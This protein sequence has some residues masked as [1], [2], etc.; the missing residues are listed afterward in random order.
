M[1][2]SL[3]WFNVFILSYCEK[4]DDKEQD[5]KGKKNVLLDFT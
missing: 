3:L 1:N 2:F 4:E 5:G